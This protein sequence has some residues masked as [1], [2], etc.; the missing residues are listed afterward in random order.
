MESYIQQKYG[1]SVSVLKERESDSIQNNLLMVRKR[2]LALR[3]MQIVSANQVKAR[4][5]Q[6]VEWF[7]P[8]IKSYAFAGCHEPDI[9]ADREKKLFDDFDCIVTWYAEMRK[10]DPDAYLKLLEGG[11]VYVGI[12]PKGAP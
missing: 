6:C 7:F 10:G 1:R 2:A 9:R 11:K 5:D 12:P 3:S 8:R 4:V